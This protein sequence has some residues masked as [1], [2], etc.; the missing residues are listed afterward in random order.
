MLGAVWDRLL[1]VPPQWCVRAPAGPAAPGALLILLWASTCLPTPQPHTQDT[2]SKYSGDRTRKLI[3]FSFIAIALYVAVDVRRFVRQHAYLQTR[4]LALPWMIVACAVICGLRHI[5]AG[6][7]RC[8]GEKLIREKYVS[9]ACSSVLARIRLRAR[10]CAW[11][12]AFAEL[13]MW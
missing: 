5:L 11:I 8:L 12:Y 6:A 3:A 10:A 1:L 4:V 13:S 2:M 9:A 7:F